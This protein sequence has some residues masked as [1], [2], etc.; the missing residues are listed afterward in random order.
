MLVYEYLEDD[1]AARAE[2]AAAAAEPEPAPV[3]RTATRA[4]GIPAFLRSADE[5]PGSR[6]RRREKPARASQDEE[7]CEAG[8]GEPVGRA[9][10][11]RL[12]DAEGAAVVQKL[13]RPWRRE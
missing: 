4:V 5:D 10:P 7:M 3:F 8:D 13:R 1:R 9:M 6:R 11:V 2:A 12:G